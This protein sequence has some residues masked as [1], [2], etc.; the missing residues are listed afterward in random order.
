FIGTRPEADSAAVAPS[1]PAGPAPVCCS[2]CADGWAYEDSSDHDGHPCNCPRGQQIAL[3]WDLD[4]LRRIFRDRTPE[5]V[6]GAMSKEVRSAIVH[7]LYAKAFPSWDQSDGVTEELALSLIDQ[8]DEA[9]ARAESLRDRLATI[10]DEAFGLHPVMDA[11]GL[12][13]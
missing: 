1:P 4:Q 11:D 2:E 13:T 12:L 10:I 9:L 7:A 8:R 5:Q 3:N 6:V